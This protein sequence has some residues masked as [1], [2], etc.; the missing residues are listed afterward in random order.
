MGMAGEEV[1]NDIIYGIGGRRGEEWH[2]LWA[3][4]E[5]RRGMIL[6]DYTAGGEVRNDI[7]AIED[8]E[9]R[10]VGNDMRVWGDTGEAVRNDNV[11][12]RIKWL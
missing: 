11:I 6:L 2:Y 4:R 3:W 5:K 8:M 9:R 1:R 12:G 10:E 7:I